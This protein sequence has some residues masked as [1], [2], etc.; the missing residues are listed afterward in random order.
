MAYEVIG[1][2][3]SSGEEIIGKITTVSTSNL[4]AQIL[5]EQQ[6]GTQKTS[7]IFNPATGNKLP[8][9]VSIYDVRLVYMQQVSATQMGMGLSPWIYGNQ[10][11]EFQINLKQHALTVYRPSKDV[12]SAYMEHTSP[13]T[14]AKAGSIPNLRG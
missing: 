7:E 4:T 2:K 1:I 6:S 14:L 5:F 11:G 9:T 12:E 10:E 13:I 3:L 8:E